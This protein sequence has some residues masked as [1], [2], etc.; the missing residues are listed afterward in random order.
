VIGGVM[1]DLGLYEDETEQKQHFGAIQ[2]LVKDVS[3]TEEEIRSLYED[4]LKE[5]KNVAKIKT[6]L[7]ILVSKR[8]KELLHAARR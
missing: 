1:K 2:K 8:V 4:V 6:F 3:S 7:S 5:F